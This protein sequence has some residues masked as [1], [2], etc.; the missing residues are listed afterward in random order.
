MLWQ[1]TTD[2]SINRFQGHHCYYKPC[3]LIYNNT[4]MFYKRAVQCSGKINHFL[5]THSWLSTALSPVVHWMP[6]SFVLLTLRSTQNRLEEAEEWK[7]SFPEWGAYIHV[8]LAIRSRWLP[9]L[10]H[11]QLGVFPRGYLESHSHP[12]SPFLPCYPGRYSEMGSPDKCHH[13]PQNASQTEVQ[14]HIHATNYSVLLNYKLSQHKLTANTLCDVTWSH[15]TL[16]KGTE[17]KL[18]CAAGACWKCTPG[19]YWSSADGLY[20]VRSP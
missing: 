6:S 11:P 13:Y 15:L 7:E 2:C 1:T 10:L 5:L 20:L 8:I 4:N 14:I 17:T 9:R 16:G 19:R 3:S 12:H 18:H